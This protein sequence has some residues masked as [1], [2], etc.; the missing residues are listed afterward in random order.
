M[1]EL[2][3]WLIAVFDALSAKFAKENLGVEIKTAYVPDTFGHPATLPKLL[4][5]IGFNGL[6]AFFKWRF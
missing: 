6:S 4:A 5:R 1:Y 3:D 2:S